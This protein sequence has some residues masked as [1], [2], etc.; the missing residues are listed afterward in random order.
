MDQTSR[1]RAASRKSNEL[2]Q[3]ASVGGQWLAVRKPDIADREGPLLCRSAK[4]RDLTAAVVGD[5][6]GRFR[7]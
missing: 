2:I 6:H 7:G 4:G 1:S 5:C 3:A